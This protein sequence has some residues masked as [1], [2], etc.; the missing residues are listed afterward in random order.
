VTSGGARLMVPRATYRLQLGRGFGFAEAV[1]ILP[2][3][4]ELGVS[5]AYCSP[6][7]RARAGSTHGYDIID[8]NA[9]NPEIGEAAA[10]DAFVA[11]LRRHAMG[12]V[13]DFV[14]NHMGVAQADNAWWLDVL[15]WGRESAFA[16]FFDIDWESSKP[17]LRGKVLLPFLGDHYG[18]TLERGELQL[19]FERDTGTF[20]VWYHEHR[21]PIAPPQY[22]RILGA[23]E[24][25]LALDPE[26]A[27]MLADA[28]EHIRHL[29]AA[30]R[31]AG[32]MVP[33]AVQAGAAK[34]LLAGLVRSEPRIGDW[35]DAR[36]ARVNGVPG[37]PRS[38]VRLHH[39][40]E[41]QHY[42]LAYWR[43]AA[44]EINY[45]RFFNVNELAG[46]CVERREAFERTHRLVLALIHDGRLDGLRID[47][48]DGLFDPLAYC[49]ALHAAAGGACWIVVEKIL[50]SDERLRPEWPVAGTTG[51]EFLNR[52]T[53]LLVD[54]AGEPTLT[55]AYHALTGEHA[56][57]EDVVYHCKKHVMN[58]LLASELQVL[59]ARLDRL[60][61]TDW[62][63]RDFTLT[64][65]R[66]AL[67]EV[68][69]CLPVY[70]TYVD[71]SG[72]T[73]DDRREIERAVGEARRR[74]AD[75][76]K[77]LFDFLG[78]VLTAEQ[79]WEPGA[80][81]PRPDVLLFAR[82]LQQFT[83]P[84]A[85]KGVE[86]TAFY[87]YHRLIALNEV[88]GDPRT[89]GTSPAAFHDHC[90][91]AARSRPHGMLATGTHDTKRGEDA[92]ARLA[93]L[94]ELPEAWAKRA[95]TWMA[96]AAPW[97]QRPGGREAPTRNE[98]YFL[99]QALLG[100][101]PAELTGVDR[102]E[103]GALAGYRQ[104]VEAYVVKALREAKEHTSWRHPNPEYEDAV[105]HFVRALLDGDRRSNRFLA[106]FLPFQARIAVLGVLK[107]LSQTL[108]KLSAPGVPDVYQ[109]SEL[110]DLS[111][112]DPDNR[113]PVDYELRRRH[114]ATLRDRFA[115]AVAP[116][117]LA[118]LL[119][120]WRDGGVKL[121]LLWRLLKFR[122]DAPALFETGAYVPLGA[123]G[124]HAG[125]LCAFARTH[126]DTQLIVVAPRLPAALHG[127]EAPCYAPEAWADTAIAL[128]GL[129]VPPAYRDL[130][131]GG[132]VAVESAD[133]APRVPLASLLARFPVAALV[134]A[135]SGASP[136]R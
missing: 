42:R 7:L 103:P 75:P 112:V 92:R 10:F 132:S 62:R 128:D 9:W 55:A 102:L 38:F 101:W 78:R 61:E 27:Q 114:L 131:T 64:S 70:R 49:E 79:G 67:K 109:G 43:V 91:E 63:W 73:A 85:A 105:L 28:L 117:A 54:P 121:F 30:A 95:G 8:H 89:F 11:A 124:R 136:H 90:A 74:S 51:Y 59:A 116:E 115:D 84:V 2:Y 96:I 108:L 123:A 82:R 110:W 118:A 18:A 133:G 120:A 14:P 60:S 3:L 97:K 99:Y 87:R 135:G 72:A 52:V 35:I 4:A 6:Y 13:L 106:D 80:E 25:H 16:E 39:L 48:V 22:G 56:P 1:A 66:E 65:L 33:L 37:R 83:G 34:R 15:E 134:S 93:A 130:I 129:P 107:S 76:E 68:V 44:D 71:A 46:L 24:R 17:E 5:H 53:G 98:E 81:G 21:F 41:A 58:F 23:P 26:P 104:R 45:R 94:S 50:A 88:G 100:S 77:T 119:H 29:G 57:F 69:A 86:D 31:R 113:R 111:L 20:S 19:R 12:H 126:A 127:G 36:V 40:L 47:H 125:R 122:R 32:V